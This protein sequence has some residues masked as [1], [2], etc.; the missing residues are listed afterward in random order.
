[1]DSIVEIFS[2]FSP[3]EIAIIVISVVGL[4]FAI[5]YGSLT[6]AQFIGYIFLIYLIFF[7]FLGASFKP[8][9]TFTNDW[10]SEM[11]NK[12]YYLAGTGSFINGN[13]VITNEHVVNHCKSVA[14]VDMDKSYAGKVVAIDNVDDLAVIMVNVKRRYSSVLRMVPLKKEEKI[15][16]PDYTSTKGE[17]YKKSGYVYKNNFDGMSKK[18]DRTFSFKKIGGIRKGNSGSPVYDENGYLVGVLNSFYSENIFGGTLETVAANAKV[19]KEF[20]D[21]SKIPYLL[22]KEGDINKNL[23]ELYPEYK[24][25][26]AVGVLCH[27]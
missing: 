14:I 25:S 21:K 22:A 20:L 4:V 13:M 8:L 1:M 12:N 2:V 10:G 6:I 26:Y 9:L 11:N 7:S 15:Y 24:D 5:I 17:F 27:E 19:I 23:F 18:P 3:Y 16:Y